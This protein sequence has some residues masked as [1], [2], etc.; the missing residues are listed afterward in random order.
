M[1][2]HATCAVAH[3]VRWRCRTSPIRTDALA[4]LRRDVTGDPDRWLE[5]TSI[6]PRA[7]RQILADYSAMVQ[8]KWFARLYLLQPITI[9]ILTLFWS[10]LARSRSPWPT[11]R[12]CR[13][14]PAGSQQSSVVSRFQS[15]TTLQKR[16]HSSCLSLA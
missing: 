1:P 5:A 12:P 7:I 16:F 6:R 11:T 15:V 14:S 8:E 10:A 4:E 9:V 13:S 2:R 3:S